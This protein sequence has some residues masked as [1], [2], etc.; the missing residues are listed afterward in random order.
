[1]HPVVSVIIPAWNCAAFLPDTLESVAAQTFKQWEVVV[2]DDGSTDRTL[3]VARKYT[4]AT[5][6]ITVLTQVNRGP[7]AAR[8][9]GV[10]TGAKSSQYLLFLDGDDLLERD[11]LGT[12]CAYMDANPEV[13]LT[14]FECS[15]I[16]SKGTELRADEIDFSPM[17]LPRYVPSYFWA[18][19]L[20][21]DEI[22]TPFLSIYNLAGIVPSL[23]FLRRSVFEQC[24]GWNED[25]HQMYEDTDLWLRMALRSRVHYLPRR[26][27]RYRR[28]SAQSTSASRSWEFE[29]RFGKLLDNWKRCEGLDPHQRKIVR[30]AEAFRV[31]GLAVYKNVR[32][33][34]RHFVSG[35]LVTTIRFAYGALRALLGTTQQSHISGIH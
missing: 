5:P 29:N 4:A 9:A 25:F 3:E 33:M 1:M 14:H 20:R 15:C 8:N 32:L 22:E 30:E 34:K 31:G 35:D 10:R 24:G 7:S 21:R 6:G 23:A 27:A 17:N 16:D 13:G 18:R 12:L 11:A 2:V 28:H 26:L 19:K